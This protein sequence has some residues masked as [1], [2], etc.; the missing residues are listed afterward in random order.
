MPEL[1]LPI[2]KDDYD[3]SV[4]KF[5]TFPPTADVGSTQVR[6]V[7]L[8][9]VDWD[10]P[11][12]SIQ[13]P[14]VV[15]E[16]GDDEGKKDKISAGIG[17]TAV[18]KLKEILGRLGIEVKDVNGKPAFNC[19]SLKGKKLFGEWIM[20]EGINQQTKKPVFY[21]KLDG[22]YLERRENVTIPKP[23]ATTSA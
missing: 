17:E 18:W 22:I 12:Q 8:K 19:D 7:E 21:P 2:S 13:F 1:V 20:Q 9:T 4:S 10:T 5:I 16:K 23:G 15:T 6:E 11:G 14:V 3:K